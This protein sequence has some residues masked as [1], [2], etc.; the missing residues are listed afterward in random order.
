MIK[1][2]LTVAACATLLWAGTALAAP[3]PQEKCDKAHVTAWK[4]YVACVDGVLA[5]DAKGSLT[6][7]GSDEFAAFAKCRHTYFKKWT[8]F[9]KNAALKGS[10]CRNADGTAVARF[11][12]NGDGT[13]TDNLTTLV[14]E[15]KDNLDGT[16]NSSDPRDADNT[17][18]WSTGS[19]YEENGTA[20]TSFLTDPTTGLN[21]TGFAGANGWRLPT[22]AELQSI[23]LDFKC[24]GAGGS[25]TCSCTSNPCIAFS[26][27]NTSAYDWSA[28]SYVPDPS[29]VWFVYFINGNVSIGGKTSGLFVR[30]VRGGL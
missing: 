9:G 5:K 3:T 15:K 21:A 11:V 30:A 27:A 29:A 17:Y 25:S 13:V 8:G 6:T 23:V 1:A 18:T 7:G 22:L 24:T 28:S 20:F 19:P 16:A 26:D 2:V 14:W 10:T 4:A 12:D